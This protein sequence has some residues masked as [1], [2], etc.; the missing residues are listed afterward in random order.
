M[1]LNFFFYIDRIG[2]K[3]AVGRMQQR[4]YNN[5]NTRGG[6][7]GGGGKTN[8]QAQENLSQAA[9][10]KMANL[11]AKF[12]NRN[13]MNKRQDRG[14]S[15]DRLPSLAIGPDWEMIDEFDL[16]NSIIKISCQSTNCRR[17]SLVWICGS[18]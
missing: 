3:R 6:R 2:A 13:G 10:N 16:S 17:F 11:R 18:I 5:N 1:Q 15:S 14:K 12:T 7:G 9:R 4:T 8:Q